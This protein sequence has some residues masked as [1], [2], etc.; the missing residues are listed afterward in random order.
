[1]EVFID[2]VAR[3]TCQATK[4]KIAK[5]KND[6]QNRYTKW[7]ERLSGHYDKQD[8]KT[9]L[10]VSAN[11]YISN[12]VDENLRKDCQKFIDADFPLGLVKRL[13]SL[14]EDDRNEFMKSIVIKASGIMDVYIAEVKF[15]Y[16]SSESETALYCVYDRGTDTVYI[17]SYYISELDQPQRTEYL[18]KSIFRELKYARQAAAI[19]DNKNYGYSNEILLDWALNFKYYTDSIDNFEAYRK[20][21]IEVDATNWA[22][23]LDNHSVLF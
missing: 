9:G 19:F 2:S 18:L 22:N 16:P 8:L 15:F 20:Q 12:S 10:S 7:N 3:N 1:M 13:E 21:A 11:K 23:S 17:N 14:S 4:S 6:I 5:W